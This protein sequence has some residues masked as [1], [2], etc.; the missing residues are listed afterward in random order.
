MII[1][2]ISYANKGMLWQQSWTL[3][4]LRETIPSK[5][6]SIAANPSWES[7]FLDERDSA[8]WPMHIE[9]NVL[10]TPRSITGR[11]SK[12]IDSFSTKLGNQHQ[13]ALGFNLIMCSSPFWRTRAS[14]YFFFII[15][16][17]KEKK[18]LKNFTTLVLSLSLK[19]VALYNL[20]EAIQ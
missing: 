15:A 11:T 1:V 19:Q 9:P 12:R 18:E 4:R 16:K 14:A 2:F 17:S 6:T 10:H 13:P 3:M 20:D 5:R 8:D 7:R